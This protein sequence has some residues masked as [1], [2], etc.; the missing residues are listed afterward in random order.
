MHDAVM[1]DSAF[2]A[3][4]SYWLMLRGWHAVMPAIFAADGH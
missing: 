1:R 3:D 2:A 4:A